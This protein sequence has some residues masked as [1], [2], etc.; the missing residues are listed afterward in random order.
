MN[1]HAN[2]DQPRRVTGERTSS[3]GTDQ[4]L[5]ALALV[6]AFYRVAADP[7]EVRHRL[8]LGPST[9]DAEDLARGARLI[10]LKSRILRDVDA[11]RLAGLPLPA[12]L[13]LGD[14]TFAVLALSA[15]KGHARIVDP[16]ARVSRESSFEEIAKQGTGEVLLLTRRLGGPGV[17]PATFGFRWFLP[18]LWRYRQPL[19]EV[20]VA[21]LFLQIFAI[22]T[23]IF[24][25]LVVDKVLVHKGT[26]TLIVLVVGLVTLGLFETL[27]QFLR[28]YTLTH[29][30]NRIDV[31]LGRRLFNH[32]FR[33]PLSYFETRPA[34]QT[35]ARVR[36]LETIRGFLTG[37]ACRRPSTSRLPSFCSLYFSSIPRA[38]HWSSLSRSR[39]M[40]SSPP[41]CA[42]PCAPRSTKSSIAARSR[43]NSSSNPLSGPRL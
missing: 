32:L 14:G 38:S 31:E 23:P 20:L 37:R 2:A 27:L 5:A 8:A 17:D 16:I 29:T 30:S 40:Y 35:V 9:A 19:G 7:D 39:S 43:S 36:E 4:G 41:P 24:F 21:S 13:A 28:T 10:G 12:I 3:A 11:R 26:S 1:A 6:A 42:L 15:D 25:Q 34:G 33:L 18:S 22:A